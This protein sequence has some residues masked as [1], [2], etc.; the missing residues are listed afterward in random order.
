MPGQGVGLLRKP[1]LLTNALNPTWAI[2]CNSLYTADTSALVKLRLAQEVEDVMLVADTSAAHST[3]VAAG[4]D[5]H[6][7][8]SD[9]FVIFIIHSFTVEAAPRRERVFC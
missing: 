1:L 4:R 5:C 3:W 2:K 9:I 6:C 7:Q 8:A